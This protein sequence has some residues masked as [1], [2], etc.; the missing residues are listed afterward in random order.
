MSPKRA[1]EDLGEGGAAF[2]TVPPALDDGRGDGLQLAQVGRA[3]GDEDGHEVRIGLIQGGDELV[4]A[5]GQ[6]DVL[7]VGAFGL[8]ALVGASEEDHQV[9]VLREGDSLGAEGG[10]GGLVDGGGLQRIL[11]RRGGSP[12]AAREVLVAGSVGHLDIG[13]GTLA[14]AFERSDFIEG[15]HTGAHTAALGL[16]DSVLADDGNLLHALRDREHTTLVLEEDDGFLGDLLGD[17]LALGTIS[18]VSLPTL[19]ESMT[20]WPR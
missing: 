17:F 9:G 19:M 6:V 18:S 12:T 15:L 1:E 2:G 8:D 14:D 5:A 4:L 11:R 16:Q 20:G 13:A 10:I 7:A 3:A